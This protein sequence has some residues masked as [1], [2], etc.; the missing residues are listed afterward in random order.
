MLNKSLV[1]AEVRGTETRY[2]MLETIRQYARTRLAE[3]G[4]DPVA[5]D[6]HLAYYA[7]LTGQAEPHIRGKGQVE[8]LSRL[9][10]EL[11]N[12]RAAMEWSLKGRIEL[13]MKIVTDLM[14]F[15]HNRDLFQ[16][17][18]IWLERFLAAESMEGDESVLDCGRLVQRAKLLRAMVRNITHLSRGFRDRTDNDRIAS[19]QETVTLLRKS[20]SCDRRELAIS[21][22][23]LKGASLGLEGPSPEREEMLE[24]LYQNKD[25]YLAEYLYYTGRNLSSQGDLDQARA[26]Q[27]EALKIS[28][29]TEDLDGISSRKYELGILSLYSGEYSRAETLFNEGI[30]LAQQVKNRWFETDIYLGLLW[31]AQAQ[32]KYQEA[33]RI[34]DEVRLRYQELNSRGRIARLFMAS[35]ADPLVAG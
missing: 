19:L 1:I 13:G 31:A 20:A 18:S 27:E 24:I 30:S 35:A 29:A 33:S 3:A 6:W 25:F 22:L 32:G 14:W 9:D 23:F 10:E 21:L 4:C 11:D 5:R 2:F 28:L 26:Y 17:Q 12:L 34:S 7:R 15:W 16:E 8:W